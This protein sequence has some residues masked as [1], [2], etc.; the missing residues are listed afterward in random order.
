MKISLSLSMLLN[1]CFVW[2]YYFGELKVLQGILIEG[3][4]RE[5]LKNFQFTLSL[6]SEEK[7]EQ[8]EIF[9]RQQLVLGKGANEKQWVFE[10]D[11]N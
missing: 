3:L 8:D 11:A 1:F 4:I 10:Y 2:R 6:L 9:C 5:I 7:V